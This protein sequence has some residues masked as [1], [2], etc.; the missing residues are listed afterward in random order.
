MEKY[1]E[2]INRINN[3]RDEMLDRK[4][5]GLNSVEVIFLD[6]K[7]R[8]NLSGNYFESKKS[9]FDPFWA[10]CYVVPGEITTIRD[11]HIRALKNQMVAILIYEYFEYQYDKVGIPKDKEKYYKEF[12]PSINF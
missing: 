3:D 4:C 6:T 7:Q 1:I 9:I 11:I 12:I 5:I 8:Y 10:G 2:E